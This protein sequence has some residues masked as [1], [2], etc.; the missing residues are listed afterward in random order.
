MRVGFER[1]KRMIWKRE[2]VLSPVP[3]CEGPGPPAMCQG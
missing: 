3:E 2:M 1:A